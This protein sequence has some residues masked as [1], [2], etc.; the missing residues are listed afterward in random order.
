MKL[1]YVLKGVENEA[2]K[3]GLEMAS[4]EENRRGRREVGVE[5][6]TWKAKDN[7]ESKR[8]TGRQ[9]TTWKAKDKF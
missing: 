9:K 7:L 8:Q 5:E 4:G 6:T 2:M 1:I 3:T